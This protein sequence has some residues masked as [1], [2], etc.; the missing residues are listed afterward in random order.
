[1]R[2]LVYVIHRVNEPNIFFL[3][4]P[5]FSSKNSTCLAFC[6]TQTVKKWSQIFEVYSYIKDSIAS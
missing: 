2:S 6:V 5:C 3:Q 4:Y 1:M